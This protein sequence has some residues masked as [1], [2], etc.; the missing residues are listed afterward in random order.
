MKINQM[1]KFLR[2]SLIAYNHFADEVSRIDEKVFK[3]ANKGDFPAGSTVLGNTFTDGS[4]KPQDVL[5]ML[6]G[7][8]IALKE[9]K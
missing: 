3:E 7:Y 1:L 5:N 9:N 8:I 4:K 2:E 6:E